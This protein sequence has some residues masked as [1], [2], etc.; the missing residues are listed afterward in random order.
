MYQLARPGNATW[1]LGVGGAC[2]RLAVSALQ[3]ACAHAQ[4]RVCESWLSYDVGH[5]S[6]AECTSRTPLFSRLLPDLRSFSDARCDECMVWGSEL[7]TKC[8][9]GLGE[10]EVLEGAE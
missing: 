9:N 5:P 8:W 4:V 10:L 2:L 7:Y 1:R 3:L 6:S